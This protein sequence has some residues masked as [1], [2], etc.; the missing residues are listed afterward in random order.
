MEKIHSLVK[1][2]LDKIR[3]YLQSDGGDIEFVDITDDLVVKAMT[4][5]TGCKLLREGWSRH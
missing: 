3:P 2:T 5:P 4:A 1:E